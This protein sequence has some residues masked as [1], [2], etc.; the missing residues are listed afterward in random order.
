MVVKKIKFIKNLVC[1][2]N[3]KNDVNNTNLIL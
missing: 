2:H 1:H 3:L